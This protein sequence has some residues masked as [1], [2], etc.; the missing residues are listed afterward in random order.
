VTKRSITI[1]GHRT[2]VSLEAAFWS[3]LEEI[4]RDEKTSLAALVAGVDRHRL[5]GTTLSSAIRLF[6]LD[7]SRSR[8]PAS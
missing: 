1:A 4:A 2:S 7:R 5:P 3:A 6:V 8:A